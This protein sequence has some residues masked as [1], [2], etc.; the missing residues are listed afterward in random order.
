M[1][2]KSVQDNKKQRQHRVMNDISPR[3]CC[4]RG[5]DA[6]SSELAFGSHAGCGQHGAA[7]EGKQDK[8]PTVTAYRL[9]TAA[10]AGAV[11]FRGRVCTQQEA[12]ERPAKHDRKKASH[13]FPSATMGYCTFLPAMS[14]HRV[15]K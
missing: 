4:C 2:R 1:K 9:C 8:T 10:D 12:H 7:A 3:I 11:T 13:P 5:L 15:V 6:Q 14:K